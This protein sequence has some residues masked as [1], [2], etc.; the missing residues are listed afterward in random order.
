M[1][2]FGGKNEWI[3][4]SSSSSKKDE[5]SSLFDFSDI[6]YK[7]DATETIGLD[8]YLVVDINLTLVHKV[9]RKKFEYEFKMFTDSKNDIACFE[10]ISK[11]QKTNYNERMME[12]IM[13]RDSFDTLNKWEKYKLNSEPI[14]KQYIP[15]MPNKVKGIVSKKD[16]S[17]SEQKQLLNII[18]LY[19]DVVD[20][21][22]GL[23]LNVFCET[24]EKEYCKICKLSYSSTSDD[25][26]KCGNNIIRESDQEEEKPEEPETEKQTNTS[27]KP[28][29]DWLNCL[30]GIGVYPEINKKLFKELDK[31]CVKNKFPTSE[32]VK[33]NP[34]EG[35]PQL[36]T[37][38][39]QI[40]GFKNFKIRNVLAREYW[41]WE[42]PSMTE[43][44]KEE[45]KRNCILT[46]KIYPFVS[47]QIANINL[48][49]TGYLLL[50]FQGLRFDKKFFKFPKDPKIIAIA[51]DVWKKTL[52]ILKNSNNSN[53]STNDSED[54]E[55]NIIFTGKI[56]MIRDDDDD[57]SDDESVDD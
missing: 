36:L 31:I 18:S 46:R 38:I 2:F 55:E 35:T 57:D 15:L 30:L 52:K 3:I 9:I 19:L 22:S 20:E 13:I 27:S 10:R 26:C 23:K 40:Y 21:F 17:L 54:L 14:L 45:F 12:L 51:N 41:G 1:D 28:Q 11:I 16:L 49:L 56:K 39:M 8:V 32:E 25:Y 44:Q 37:T 6:K 53:S 5:L 48:E 29:L 42:L 24:E 47:N 50:L 34:Q 43:E 4:P 33:M 7:E